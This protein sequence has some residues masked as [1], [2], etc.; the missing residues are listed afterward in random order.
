MQ[1]LTLVASGLITGWALIAAIGAQNAYL[2]RQGLRREHVLPLVVFCIAS[3]VIL[4]GVAVAGL[5]VALDQWPGLLPVARWAGGLF[6][7]GYGVHAAWRARRP[8]ERLTAAEGVGSGL[9]LRRAVL[10]MAALT[11][12]NPHLYVDIM[13]L[14][15]VANGHGEVARWWFYAGLIV[16][17]ITWF[18][19]LGFGSGRLQPLFARPRAWQVL[20]AAVAVCM[21]S[22]GT[23]LIVQG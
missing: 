3:D 17:S 16:A 7:I 22:L 11:W 12:L 5:G 10:T 18:V 4:I 8:G 14:G 19:T 23:A 6:V 1:T 20:D 13:M 15:A 2:L 9:T 21:V